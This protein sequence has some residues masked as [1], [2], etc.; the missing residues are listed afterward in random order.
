[1]ELGICK[2]YFVVLIY[3]FAVLRIEIRAMVQSIKAV[4]NSVAPRTRLTEV[5]VS[6]V[7]CLN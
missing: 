4:L 1:M 2:K 3:F 5:H 6:D 7:T